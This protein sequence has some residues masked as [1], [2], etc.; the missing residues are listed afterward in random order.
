M[1]P[2]CRLPVV[3]ADGRA[4]GEAGGGVGASTGD[5]DGL[6]LDEDSKEETISF[7]DVCLSFSAARWRGGTLSKGLFWLNCH[8][9]KASKQEEMSNGLHQRHLALERFLAFGNW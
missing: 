5:V 9:R 1:L 2:A 7:S 8:A 4:G 6:S 3:S